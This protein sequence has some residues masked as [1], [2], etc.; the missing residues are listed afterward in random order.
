MQLMKIPNVAWL[1]VVL[2]LGAVLAT[3]VVERLGAH[4][5]DSS[6]VHGCIRDEIGLVVVIGENEDCPT[7]WTARDWE[8]QGPVG[9]PG[10]AGSLGP[11]GDTGPAEAAGAAGPAGSP[12]PKGDTGPA[13]AAGPA[14]SP[15][16]RGDTGPVG[17]LGPRGVT[18]AEGITGPDGPQGPKGDTGPT[19]AAGLDG[20]QGPKGDTGLD[21]PQGPPGS[22]GDLG[23]SALLNTT[24]LLATCTSLASFSTAYAKIL[25]VG[26]F[27]KTDS[28]SSVEITFNGRIA[29]VGSVSGSGAYFELRVDNAATTKGR[30]RASFK[31][32]EVGSDGVLASITG[33]FPGLN[34]GNHTVSI[35]VRT[36]QGTGTSAMVDPGCWSSDH[37]VVREFQ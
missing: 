20:P 35:W 13:G 21:G 37:V 11:K 23:P 31:S 27:F 9:P 5:G 34:S 8:I 22:Q 28:V 17:N 18:G 30:A 14:G 4:G 1:G 33:I 16:P 15:G 29:V 10:P 2:I 24:V 7:N 19:G 12:G 6:L 3:L 32:A 25:D 26:S 36:S